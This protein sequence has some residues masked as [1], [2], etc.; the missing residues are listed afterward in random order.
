MIE[1]YIVILRSSGLLHN[2]ELAS[3]L[4]KS[5]YNN[6]KTFSILKVGRVRSKPINLSNTQAVLTTSSN[7]IQVLAAL[8]KNRNI[9]LFTVGSTSKVIA[10]KFGFKNVIDC[11]GDSVKM[12]NVILS[13]V[14]KNKGKLVYIGAESLS[15]DLPMMLRKAG[16]EIKRY[17]VYKTKE[18]SVIN[19]NFLNLLKLKKIEWILLLSKKGAFSFNKLVVDKV[20]HSQLEKIKFACLSKN[21]SLE[22]SEKLKYKFFP[23]QPTLNKLVSTIMQNE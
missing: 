15:L 6:I 23:V 17:I 2:D 8:K 10:K 14:S 7:S 22:L 1:K 9:P 12:Y 3:T 16:Y 20:E 11:K 13:R 21:I 5:G 4:K 19:N 18:V